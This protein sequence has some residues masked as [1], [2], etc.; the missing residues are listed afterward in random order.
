MSDV[1]GVHLHRDPMQNLPVDLK[2]KPAEGY[3]AHR[4]SEIQAPHYTRK[5]PRHQSSGKDRPLR[6]S[7]RH[8]FSG[9]GRKYTL[10]RMIVNP[11]IFLYD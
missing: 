11:E 4:I 3:F 10:R 2:H 8:G 6:R 9:T 7:G 1:T 5:L